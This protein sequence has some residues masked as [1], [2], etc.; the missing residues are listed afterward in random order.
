M[1]VNG[2]PHR[3]FQRL[4]IYF[5]YKYIFLRQLLLF[6]QKHMC[7]LIYNQHLGILLDFDE[8]LEMKSKGYRIWRYNRPIPTTKLVVFLL[9]EDQFFCIQRCQCSTCGENWNF[10]IKTFPG[11]WH[12]F[13]RSVARL[14]IV[15]RK[16]LLL[17]PVRR[18]PTQFGGTQPLSVSRKEQSARAVICFLVLRFSIQNR[19][20]RGLHDIRLS[21]INGF[22]M[23]KLGSRVWGASLAMK[24]SLASWMSSLSDRICVFVY[25]F[26][27][28]EGEVIKNQ[29][30]DLNQVE[31]SLE[32]FYYDRQ[33]SNL[34]VDN[35]FISKEFRWKNY[36]VVE[37]F[38]NIGGVC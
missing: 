19:I 6:L 12:R 27:M 16:T 10:I 30:K 34:L 36:D 23:D 5:Y 7:Q 31:E 1:K 18:A 22:L 15:S 32:M 14:Y 9:K 29:S 8:S 25:L 35:L 20:G 3:N 33:S 17:L 37:C 26:V 2:L 4:Y 13:D 24:M 21:R 38:N 28:P 11:G